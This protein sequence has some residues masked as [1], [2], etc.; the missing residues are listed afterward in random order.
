MDKKQWDTKLGSLLH[1]LGINRNSRVDEIKKFGKT[2]EEIDDKL[3]NIMVSYIKDL[4]DEIINNMSSEDSGFTELDSEEGEFNSDPN[5]LLNTFFNEL[6]KGLPEGMKDKAENL[7]QWDL[8]FGWFEELLFLNDGK[9][10]IVKNEKNELVITFTNDEVKDK[11]GKKISITD[12]FINSF[13]SS[14]GN[15]YYKIDSDKKEQPIK[16]TNKSK[17]TPQKKNGTQRTKKRTYTK[18]TKD[19]GTE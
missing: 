3:T 2:S 11:N 12:E 6:S 14:N 19:K 15:I 18:K 17:P 16:N 7:K 1:S 9:F 4:H 5:A 8:V 10:R 13:N